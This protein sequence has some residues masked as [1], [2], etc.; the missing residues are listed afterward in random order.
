MNPRANPSNGKTRLAGVVDKP[1]L[2][3]VNG[4]EPRIW[5]MPGGKSWGFD[6]ALNLT[7]GIQNVTVAATDGAG[8]TT[9]QLWTVQSGGNV[10]NFTY[11]AN[12]D[13][14]TKTMEPGTSMA[15][16]SNYTWSSMGQLLSVQQGNNTVSF[17]YD[18]NGRR[19]SLS[20][21]IAGN[22]TNEYY[23][24]DG[25]QIVQER[26][27]GNDSS[28]IADK[29]FENGFQTVGGGNVTGNYF[30]TKDH[31]GSVRE[32]VDGSGTLQ[33]RFDYGPWGETTYMDYSG[34]NMAEPQFGYAGY[35]Q[36][37]Y[38]P[39]EY[40][41]KYRIYEP[42][43][44]RWLSRD[45]IGERGGLDLYGYVGND[46][47]NWYDSRGLTPA[48]AAAVLAGGGTALEGEEA[49]GWIVG[50]NFNPA[51]DIGIGATALGTG[52]WA[53]WE[54]FKPAVPMPPVVHAQAKP[55]DCPPGTVP[56]DTPEGRKRLPK[57]VTPHGVK[58]EL[59]GE[60]G[61][62]ATDWTGVAPNG[63][64]ITGA[65]DGSHINNGPP[66]ANPSK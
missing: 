39:N 56:I 38:V 26:L 32:V 59:Q 9:T 8:H 12:G 62:G 54:Y 10:A 64:I 31:L 11:N 48:A 43:I 53:I 19:V 41:T 22:V 57:G 40:F 2:V 20:A 17:G 58:G 1:A 6:A 42:S 15:V 49:G 37:A 55:K 30:Y 25:D 35:M 18:G 27:S 52:I 45:P 3:R 4:Q 61:G 63:D 44:H 23:L 13:T 50:G 16:T 33:G 65:P 29:Y 66:T 7:T 47:I 5:S 24:W 51:V 28:N 60:G 34:G 21:N 46:P 36:T 14:L